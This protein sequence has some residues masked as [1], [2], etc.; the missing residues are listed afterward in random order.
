[1]DCFFINLKS[2]MDQIIYKKHYD[3]DTLNK[4]FE[5]VQDFLIR[6][7]RILVGG[8]AMDFALREKGSRIYE[9]DKMPDYDCISPDPVGDAYELSQI[10]CN[11]LSDSSTKVSAISALHITTMKVRYN[12]EEAADITYSPIPI[13]DTP[14]LNI[15]IKN[16]KKIKVIHPHFQLLDMHKS[17]SYPFMNPPREVIFNRWEKDLKRFEI[18]F[19][20][21]PVTTELS[22][23]KVTNHT[24][25]LKNIDMSKQCLLGPPAFA[26]LVRSILDVVDVIDPKLSD[27][28]SKELQ[29]PINHKGGKSLNISKNK[30][31]NNKQINNK[32]IN[33]KESNKK[34]IGKQSSRHDDLF[35]Y[36]GESIKYFSYDLSENVIISNNIVELRENILKQL[37][38]TKRK[39]YTV[40]HF[41]PILDNRQ[42]TTVMTSNHLPH[43]I[44]YDNQN[45][46]VSSNEIQF[47]G[48][49]KI[50]IANAQRQLAY[51]LERFLYEKTKIL[52][53]KYSFYYTKI[54]Y[55]CNT[56][57]EL[58]DNF[59][60]ND[61]MKLPIFPSIQMYGEKNNDESYLN[62]RETFVEKISGVEGSVNRPK[63]MYPVK[64]KN[65]E[66]KEIPKDK[67]F[68]YDKSDFFSIDGK[69]IKAPL[70]HAIAKL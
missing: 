29:L 21:Y 37:N 2:I 14:H 31:E 32:T 28:I 17:L 65:C 40:K 70:H 13:E 62:F 41:N 52:R 53:N 19:E 27:K 48:S 57:T 51:F 49:K 54:L 5:I 16:G 46:L 39:T 35:S 23:A 4:V 45:R 33:N 60:E 20:H 58:L 36:D 10:L 42:Q 44:L 26:A 50:I 63:N 68:T 18:L 25:L 34:T 9:D 8:M 38:P 61:L 1:M 7:N 3:Y 30:K 22:K 43:F 56:I 15:S 12:F 47:I 67:Q 55:L 11:K 24:T 69:E 64:D 66:L 59:K 6:K